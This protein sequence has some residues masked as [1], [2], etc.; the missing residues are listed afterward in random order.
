MHSLV[1]H[2]NTG[3]IHCELAAIPESGVYYAIY[4]FSKIK[5]WKIGEWNINGLG[6]VKPI[7][8][9]V[10]KATIMPAI[11]INDNR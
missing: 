3:D 2:D 6:S 9:V 11:L 10:G 8:T 4:W 7:L 5:P 1:V